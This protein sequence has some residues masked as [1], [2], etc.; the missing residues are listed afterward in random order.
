MTTRHE[1]IVEILLRQ[2]LDELRQ[3]GR[4]M[5]SLEEDVEELAPEPAAMSA[6]L[7]I[8]PN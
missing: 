2:I 7:V 3:Q 6:T 1:Q 5:R 8:T 4:Q